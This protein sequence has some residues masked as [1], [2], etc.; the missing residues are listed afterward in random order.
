MYLRFVATTGAYPEPPR[1]HASR[2]LRRRRRWGVTPNSRPRSRTPMKALTTGNTGLPLPLLGALQDLLG[3]AGR[4]RGHRGLLVAHE[5]LS[6]AL[7]RDL[8]DVPGQPGA[9]HQ[10]DQHRRRIDLVPTQAMR[11]R[12]R[13]RVMVVMP[14]LPER[15]DRQPE[16]VRR[17]ILDVEATLP[18]EMTHGIDRPGHVMLEEDAHEPAPDKAGHRAHQTPRQHPAQHSRNHQAG[19]HDQREATV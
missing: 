4:V 2:P 14:A 17:L 13:E 1:P 7:R 19:Q 11:G 8:H 12:A 5:L 18:E 3:L 6:L 9:P 16:H 15:R 10:P